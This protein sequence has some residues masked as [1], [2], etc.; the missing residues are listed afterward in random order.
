M[1]QF[2]S[3][4]CASLLALSM[5]ATTFDYNA[6]GTQDQTIDGIHIV[7]AKANG[8]TVP[9]YSSYNGMKMPV[10]TTSSTVWT[11]C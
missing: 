5:T 2:F 8:S 1:K 11:S 6:D 3:L 10:P 7:L 4:V 9:A